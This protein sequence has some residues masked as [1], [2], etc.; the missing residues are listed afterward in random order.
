MI[1]IEEQRAL[2]Q[3]QPFMTKCYQEWENWK[4]G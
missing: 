1:S 2:E 4:N 3:F